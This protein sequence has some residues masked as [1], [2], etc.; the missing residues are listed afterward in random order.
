M[1]FFCYPV[2]LYDAQVIEVLKALNFWGQDEPGLDHTNDTCS[3]CSG[4]HGNYGAE[5]AG[6]RVP[7]NVSEENAPYYD[8]LTMAAAHQIAGS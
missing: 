1:R 7:A 8:S 5:P 6:P 4:A 2:G 3:P